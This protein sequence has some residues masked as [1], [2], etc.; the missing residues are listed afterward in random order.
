MWVRIVKKEAHLWVPGVGW[1]QI[2]RRAENW[3]GVKEC[4]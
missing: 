2:L 4:S 3:L 1:E